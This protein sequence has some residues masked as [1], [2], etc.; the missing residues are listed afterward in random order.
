M[1]R[2]SH[3]SSQV[4]PPTAPYAGRRVLDFKFAPPETFRTIPPGGH[5]NDILF[6]PDA[7]GRVA[8]RS[9]TWDDDDTQ[10]GFQARTFE[11]N[12]GDS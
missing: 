5:Y 3:S 9:G 1:S 7:A 10:V 2:P 8:T 11:E 4:G 12:E 6:K